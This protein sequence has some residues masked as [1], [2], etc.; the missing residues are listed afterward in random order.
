[1]CY[2]NLHRICEI[3]LSKVAINVGR[4]SLFFFL[5]ENCPLVKNPNVRIV[6]CVLMIYCGLNNITFKILLKD[7][8]YGLCQGNFRNFRNFCEFGPFGQ[9]SM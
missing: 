6:H 3:A 2:S 5:S 1:M 4:P 8:V 9:M 7:I